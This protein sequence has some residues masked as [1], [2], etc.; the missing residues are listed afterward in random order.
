MRKL[1]KILLVLAISLPAIIFNV[2]EN[3]SVY[4]I[5]SG[6]YSYEL[7]DEDTITILNYSGSEKNLVIP[8]KIDKKTV[9]KIGYGAF[10]EC[11]SIE[12]L[13]IPE[14]VTTIDN[15]AFSQC[16]QLQTMTIPD[17]V[18]SLGQNAFAGC[19]S[20]ESLKIPSEIKA[21]SY[22]AFFDC[23]SLKSVEIPDGVQTI[24]GMVF[25]NCK[26]LE[27]IILPNTITYIG[28]NAFSDCTGLKSINLPNGV[29]VLGSG[30]FKGCLG[31]EEVM[32]PDT[33]TSIGQS[34]FQDCISL[35]SIAIPNSVT[36][37]GYAAFSGCTSLKDI[38][39][40]ELV[41][42]I[43]NATFSGCASLETIEIPENI[44]SLADNVFSGCV[45]LKSIVIP[46]SV[47]EIG[48]S[49]FSY[50]SSLEEVK[51]SK[52]LTSIPT[53]LFRYCDKLETVVLPNGVKTI[54]DTVFADCMN[55]RSVTFPD[56]IQSGQIG[57]RIFSNSPKV[58]AS[59][60]ADS[61]A[62]LYMRRNA[63]AF[64]LITTGINLD[65]VELTLNVNDSSK[66]VA[67]LSPYTIAD[68]TQLTWISS[69]PNIAAIDN[70]GIVT[71]VSE[72][73][74][75]I[76]VK[77]ANGLSATSNVTI[78][79]EHIPIV[80]VKLNQNEL[81]MKKETS[82]SLKATINPSNTTE[83]KKLTWTSSDNEVVTVSST[84]VLTARKPGTVTITVTTSNG[85]S[86][87]CNV[88][89]ISEITKVALN[90]TAVSLEEGTS[91]LL[92]ATIN[93]SD[94]TDS[95]E[96]TWKSSNP[97]VAT[98][99]QNGEVTAVKKGT[100]TIT[101][102]TV[103]G[104]RAECK[105]TVNPAVVSI[106]IENI[107]LNKTELVLEEEASETL[108]ATINPSNTTD[109]KTLNWI[110]SDEAVA[111]VDQNGTIVAKQPGTAIITVTT[112][113]DKTAICE[114]TVTKKPVPIESVEL[115]KN[116]LILK[117][118][119]SETLVAT[120]NPQNTTEDTRLDW[121][122]S[123]ETVATVENGT[124]S[125]KRAGETVIT[126]TT[127]NGKEDTCLVTVFEL[128]TEELKALIDEAKNKED[129]YTKDSYAVLVDA[130]SNGEAVINDEDASQENIDAAVELLKQ[131]I[132]N[133]V[134]RVSA[135]LLETL[136]I[137]LEECKNL[138]VNYTPEEFL[139][140]K[141]VIDEAEALLQN[142][143]DNI[144]NDAVN[145][146]LSKLIEE[147]DVLYLATATNEL[148]TV[149]ASANELLNSDLSGYLEE[150][151][152]ALRTVTNEAQALIDNQCQ[153]LDLIN[154]A[155]KKVN[156]A[157]SQM[158]KIV[159]KTALEALIS[160]A[161][162]YQEGI[163]T[164]DSWAVLQET[165]TAAKEVVANENATEAEVEE[166]INNLQEAIQN[167]VLRADK[168]RLQEV[169]DMIDGLDRSLYTPASLAG[170][171][172]PM[173]NAKAVL[174]NLDASQEETDNA[175]EE[176]VRGY[177]NLRLKAIKDTIIGFVNKV[178]DLDQSKY[179]VQSWEQFETALNNAKEIIADE[180]A[181]QDKTDDAYIAL[182]NAYLGLRLK[183][184]KSMLTV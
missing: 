23:T 63:Y 152:T 105:V 13:V 58:V 17:S 51:L 154:E 128:N 47:R 126:V 4:A 134:E 44:T 27:N 85:I 82:S 67:I 103:N 6:D 76:T 73:E 161:E 74:A 97:S 70:N 62:H 79:D 9:K 174:D 121:T 52:N 137:K 71:G 22:G 127:V 28:G 112:T 125:A 151:I 110:S 26:S 24:S 139:Q 163:Y 80:G 132:D 180:N 96:L 101:V 168:T 106:P 94:T 35:E 93:P 158:Q 113:N 159:D 138:E 164:T 10:A 65:K 86:D 98:V 19:S 72:G 95:K 69:N 146:I 81:V 175:Y 177:L 8:E 88:T 39:I 109:D 7:I 32:L 184:N 29:K 57:S 56:T 130:V 16:S 144:S 156:T 176:L 108:V 140:L 5:I 55:L 40:P 122:S 173:E 61:E 143:V 38:N 36:G 157:I 78:S 115:N 53:S 37:I 183:P 171:T 11:K 111:T 124:I 104:K 2:A 75:T 54:G 135:E 136:Q 49:T 3:N 181:L 165:L 41:V 46:D 68:N 99:D 172:E 120:I 18:V 149:I 129:I 91:Q 170:L 89:V 160:E 182:V 100:A 34:A 42:S 141:E 155:V 33:L 167:L 21:I 119:K 153:D 123:D 162:I 133:L 15:Y 142:E 43:G 150:S 92:R 12:S 14:T 131:A 77:T 84:G 179:S 25:G 117:A 30:A 169:Y 59:V 178:N 116:E 48:T 45:N 102:E 148:K 147:S 20:L 31:L 1:L 83:D 60:I 90:L 107:T 50:C 118:G 166:A 145:Q 87:T 64:T 114:V 66:Y